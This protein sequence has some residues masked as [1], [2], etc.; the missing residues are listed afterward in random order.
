MIGSCHISVEA[1]NGE[2]EGNLRVDG[3]FFSIV[4]L[5]VFPSLHRSLQICGIALQCCIPFSESVFRNTN[6][7]AFVMEIF[8]ESV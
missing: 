6:I 8:N 5:W 7:F 1:I 4:L 2:F 3:F